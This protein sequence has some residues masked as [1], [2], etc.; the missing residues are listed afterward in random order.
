MPSGKDII[1]IT[2]PQQCCYFGACQKKFSLFGIHVRNFSI[3]CAKIIRW[4]GVLP[5]FVVNKRNSSQ[6]MDHYLTTVLY[7]YIQLTAYALPDKKKFALHC[8]FS[9][10]FSDRC[11]PHGMINM[12]VRLL[13]NSPLLW[14]IIILLEN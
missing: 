12:A 10:R 8:I 11:A 9:R 1:R 14:L 2:S 3:I 7:F 5:Q 6:L 13:T 4:A